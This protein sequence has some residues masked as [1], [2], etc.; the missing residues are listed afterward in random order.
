MIHSGFGIF[1]HPAAAWQQYPNAD[2]GIR[3]SKSV[4]AEADGETPLPGYQLSAPFP[5]GLPAPAGNAAGLGIDVGDSVA[6]PLRRQSVSYQE[7]WSLDI[8]R[9]LPG[10]FVV[11]AAYV[12]NEGVHLMVNEQLN[13]LPD[14]DEALGSKLLTL[15]PNP[16][17]GL[18]DPASS[19]NTP[20]VQKS[21]LLRPHPQYQNFEAL[22]VGAGH[23]SYHAG[24][25]TV[26]HRLKHGLAVVFA[27]TYSK[28]IDNVGEMTSVAGTMG[29]LTDTYCPKCDR[30]RSDQNE[31]QVIRLSARYE[32]PFGSGKAF[33]NQG[34]VK[35]IVG[36]WALSGI[37]QLDAGRPLAV[38]Y[39]DVSDLDSA[40]TLSRPNVVPGVSDKEPGGSQ[41]KLGGIYFNKAAF[42]ATPTFSFGTANRYLP[43]VN[44]PTAW[45]L[46]TMLEKSTQ[47]TT[48]CALSLRVEMFNAL[49][50]VT[51]NGPTTSFTS[52]TFGEVATL[53]QSNTPRN[54]QLSV[55]LSF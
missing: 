40:S 45:D 46:D 49:N 21:Q 37:Y 4:D 51:F 3:T 41:I 7:N 17:Y 8:Q 35:H 2:G 50:N 27:Y 36:G 54:V 44:S 12:G 15:V 13:Q 52:S 5:V 11:T 9:T 48:R 42:T 43:D 32:L 18:I 6:G 34:F 28:A 29:A 38:S 24:Q 31:P 14:A 19:V 25:L 53:T 23:S 30:S 10:D 39:T 26:E 33:L 47:L 20:T 55:R 1:H 22:N 16:L